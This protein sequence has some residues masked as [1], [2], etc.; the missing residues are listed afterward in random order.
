MANRFQKRHYEMI[1]RLFGN[2]QVDV[3][4]INSFCRF[5]EE[6]NHSFNEDLFRERI[7]DWWGIEIVYS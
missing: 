5:F 2:C 3:D 4:T 7:D 1:A 6:D